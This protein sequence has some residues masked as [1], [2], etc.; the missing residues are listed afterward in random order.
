MG[1]MS[2]KLRIA[3]V[4]LMAHRLGRPMANGL[5]SGLAIDGVGGFISLIRRVAT[6]HGFFIPT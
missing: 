5:R 1:K 2:D 4:Q 3:I 6:K